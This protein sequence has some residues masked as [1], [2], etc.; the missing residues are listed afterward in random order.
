VSL[1]TGKYEI[2]DSH[3]LDMPLFT[4][5]LPILEAVF[6]GFTCS[7]AGIIHVNSRF[8]R[9]VRTLDE[10]EEL[11][12]DQEDENGEETVTLEQTDLLNDD[13][14]FKN[15]KTFVNAK[16]PSSIVSNKRVSIS[17]ASHCYFISRFAICY[18][19]T[20]L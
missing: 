11:W 9:D 13:S 10:E 3:L 16:P 19:L 14:A 12:F 4:V 18:T 15:R 2:D 5:H 8:R 17:A 6:L 7:R 1:V 20:F